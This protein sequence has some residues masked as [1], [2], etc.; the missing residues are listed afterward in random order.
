MTRPERI[1]PG[2]WDPMTGAGWLEHVAAA[3]LRSAQVREDPR[4]D[5]WVAEQLTPGCRGLLPAA[6]GCTACFLAAQGRFRNLV[7]VDPEPAQLALARLKLAWL[8]SL[9]PEQRMALLGHRPMAMNERA[10]ALRDELEQRGFA[11]DRFGALDQVAAQGLDHAGRFELLLARLGHVLGSVAGAGDLLDRLV[12]LDRPDRQRA[13]LDLHPELLEGLAAAL[14]QV[15]TPAILARLFGAGAASHPERPFPDYFHR[16]LVRA[17]RALPAANNPYLAQFLVGRTRT[18]PPLPW[19]TLARQPV[20]TDLTFVQ[21]TLAEAL[22]Q[23]SE[24]LDF[25]DL[26]NALDGLE[27]D[28]AR[29]LLDRAAA[30]LAPGGWVV[31]RQLNSALPVHRLGRRIR[32]RPEASRALY[33]WDRSFLCTRLHAGSLA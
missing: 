17:L 27:W 2:A 26:S 32:W 7:L 19:L 23:D 10:R 8:E 15:M 28:Q 33:A 9:R 25:I 22:G 18:P 21:A 29:E 30:R 20:R 5:A 11:P 14:D 3:P 12:T 16:Q 6:G 31:V 13:F 4:T 1:K 24:P